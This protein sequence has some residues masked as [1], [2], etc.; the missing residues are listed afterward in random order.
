MLMAYAWLAMH[1]ISHAYSSTVPSTYLLLLHSELYCELV[2]F[3]FYMMR[4]SSSV[5]EDFSR[6]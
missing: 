4:V 5:F 3:C 2:G 1:A 6:T